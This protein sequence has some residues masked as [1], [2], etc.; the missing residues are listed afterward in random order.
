[1]HLPLAVTFVAGAVMVLAHFIPHAPF[2]RAD[3]VLSDFFNIIAVFALLLGG[4]N[5]LRLHLTK[6]TQRHP[7]TP[8][9]LVT[10]VGFAVMLVAGLFRI[11]VPA[12]QP[13][14]HATGL[15]QRIYD[16][17]Y[18]PLGAT[19]FSLLAFFVASAAFRAFRARTPESTLLLLAAFVILIGRTPVGYYLTAWLPDQLSLLEIPN[20]SAFIMSSFNTAGQRAIQIGIALGIV[21]TSLKIILGLERSYLGRD[22]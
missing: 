8:Y 17:T 13:Y 7:E 22:D 16:A 10:L 5:L 21:A 2:S 19:M 14:D 18:F 4:G 1:L 11:G 20:L 3:S 12:A 6:V 9:S 15:F